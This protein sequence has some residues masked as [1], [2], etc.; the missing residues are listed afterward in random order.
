MT[1][2]TRRNFLRLCGTSSISLALAACGISSTVTPVPTPIPLP[3]A[4]VLPFSTPTLIITPTATARSTN[5]LTPTATR[6][7]IKLPRTFLLDP[8]V[9]T[10]IKG[11]VQTSDKTIDLA[12][13]KLVTDANSSLVFKP[14]SVMEKSQVADS[15]NKHDYLSLAR[16]YWPDPTKPNGLPYISRDGEV[17]PEIDTIPDARNLGRVIS[18]AGT[19]ALAYLFTDD[20]KYAQKAAEILRVWFINPDTRMNPNATYAQ[21]KKGLGIPTGTG[22]IDFAEM[23]W[24]ADYIN[25]LDGSNAWTADDQQAMIKWMGDFLTWLTTSTPGINESKTL[26]NHAVYYD[27]QVVTLALFV[28][29]NDGAKKVIEDAKVKRIAAQIEPDGKQPQELARTLSMHYSIYNLGAF[30][31]LASLAERIGIDLWNYQTSDGRSIRKALDFLVPYLSGKEKW[32]Y[33]Q[34]S[35]ISYSEVSPLYLQAGVKFNNPQYTE[36]GIKVATED[37]TRSRLLLTLGLVIPTSSPTLTRTSTPR[38]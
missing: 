21:V 5:T 14:V 26:N 18:N 1:F 29:K 17:N 9:L 28:D 34:I 15:G 37:L 11:Q 32:T 16:Y 31:R 24:L 8:R 33:P 22:I 3:T 12:F 2:L 23:V 25:L 13:K 38:P 27:T 6:L 7:P 36:L 4:T 35:P 19:L 10:N 20:E 30:T